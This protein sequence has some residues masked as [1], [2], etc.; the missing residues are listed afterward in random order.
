MSIRPVGLFASCIIAIVGTAGKADA[1]AFRFVRDGGTEWLD[2]TNEQFRAGIRWSHGAYFFANQVTGQPPMFYTVDRNGTLINSAR[3]EYSDYDVFYPGP[4]DRMSDGTFVFAGMTE[5]SPRIVSPFLAWTSMDGHVQHM[6]RTGKYLIYSLALAPDD[7]IWT[8]GF[9]ADTTNPNW[10]VDQDANALRHF[11]ASGQL[12]NSAFPLSEFERLQGFKAF[13]SGLLTV[14]T[15]R[16][17]WYKSIGG[18]AVYLEISLKDFSVKTYPGASAHPDVHDR[19][20]A[21]AIT[22]GGVTSVTI[23][24]PSPSPRKSYVLDPQSE[25]WTAVEVPHFG[26]SKFPPRLI[27]VDNQDLVFLAGREAAFFNIQ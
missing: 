16:I 6:L 25:K 12:L 18:R 8:L 1:P 23:Q 14:S 3:F 21:V 26:N 22:N 17:G 2:S 10:R 9:E 15:D 20:I 24:H 19:P 7:T 13:A 4:F 27:G 11:D 5:S